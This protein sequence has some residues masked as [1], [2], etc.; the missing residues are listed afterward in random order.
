MG[1][2]RGWGLGRW[3]IGGSG[4]GMGIGNL[5]HQNVNGELRKLQYEKNKIRKIETRAVD[6][7]SVNCEFG[8]TI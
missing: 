7:G 6:V 1:E 3:R 8:T 4:G 2:E 5:N